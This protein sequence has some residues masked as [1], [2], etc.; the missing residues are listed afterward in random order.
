MIVLFL[1]IHVFVTLAMIGLILLQKSDS[2][3]PFGIGG[4]QNSLFTARGVA[5]ILTRATAVLATLFIGNC[6]LIGILTDRE[7]K[8]ESSFFH[9]SKLEKKDDK[10]EEIPSKD[11][12]SQKTENNSESDE[13]QD[14]EYSSETGN[15]SESK[16]DKI[17][18]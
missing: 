1:I 5:N 4:G 6:I 2:S 9:V 15:N 8:K 7:I 18:E 14:I 3:G 12:N 10:K 16:P 11:D 17:K 13:P